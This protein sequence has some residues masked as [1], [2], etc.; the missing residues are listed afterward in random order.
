MKIERKTALN[1]ELYWVLLDGDTPV[2]ISEMYKTE[3]QR[4]NGIEAF[5]ANRLQKHK[6]KTQVNGSYYA[7]F[8]ASN[9]ALIGI[10]KSVNTLSE[11]K[12]LINHIQAIDIDD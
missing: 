4:D 9:N 1:G 6:I 5:I 10:T 3:A 12:D 11:I 7:A 2:F 8:N